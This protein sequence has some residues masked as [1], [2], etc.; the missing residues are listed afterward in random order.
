M[1][2]V[3]SQ[4][5]GLGKQHTSRAHH[6]LCLLWMSACCCRVWPWC[7][8]GLYPLFR[9]AFSASICDPLQVWRPGPDLASAGGLLEASLGAV[10]HPVHHIQVQ[11]M[12][13]HMSQPPFLNMHKC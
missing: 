8:A 2:A 9:S 1:C 5:L 10:P 11:T 7:L 4:Y 6:V 12:T 13:T 3:C